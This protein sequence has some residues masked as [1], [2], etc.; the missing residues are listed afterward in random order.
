MRQPRL[1]FLPS[2]PQLWETIASSGRAV[3]KQPHVLSLPCWEKPHPVVEIAKDAVENMLV[4][5]HSRQKKFLRSG[6]DR[7]K[8]VLQKTLDNYSLALAIQ[9]GLGRR[10]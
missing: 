5:S 10:T 9:A 8:R 7:D 1:P 2:S 6:T 4:A 3:S